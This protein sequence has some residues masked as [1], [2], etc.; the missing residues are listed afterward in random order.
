MFVFICLNGLFL[1]YVNAIYN[2]SSTA[3]MQFDWLYVEP[4]VFAL[5]VYLDYARVFENQQAALFYLAYGTWIT[6]KYLIFMHSMV[7]QIT[8]Y[9]QISFL[10]VKP[11][12]PKKTN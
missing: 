9:L 2:L 3:G 8:S 4:Y 11:F 12:S 10:K 5:I 7:D 1:L 6:V